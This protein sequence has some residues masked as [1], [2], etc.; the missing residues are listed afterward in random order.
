MYSS[1]DNN[2]VFI[3]CEKETC[4]DGQ[5]QEVFIFSNYQ[6]KQMRFTPDEI[7]KKEKD[8]RDIMNCVTSSVN[9]KLLNSAG[10]S[11]VEPF[12]QSLNF[13]GYLCK[14]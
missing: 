14:K 2:G 7:L 6:Y 8:L 3:F 9:V 10:F 5:F 1:L 13:K 11:I 12:F 4:L